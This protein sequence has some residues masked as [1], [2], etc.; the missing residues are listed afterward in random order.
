MKPENLEADVRLARRIVRGCNIV[1]IVGLVA[2]VYGIIEGIR[3]EQTPDYQDYI[4]QVGSLQSFEHQLVAE[5]VLAYNGRFL[6]DH[7]YDI[8]IPTDLRAS[9][10][11]KRVHEM[12]LEKVSRS[13]NLSNSPIDQAKQGA[14]FGLGVAAVA[15]VYG[16]LVRRGSTL[17]SAA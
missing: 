2:G 3:Y 15:A 10:W 1:A 13:V 14:T 6:G 16:Y 7:P 5:G 4:S 17:R 8:R 9:E 11:G 12:D